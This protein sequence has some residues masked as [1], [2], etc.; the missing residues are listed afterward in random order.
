MR[1]TNTSKTPKPYLYPLKL[2]SVSKQSIIKLRHSTIE[3]S[4]QAVAD[5]LK[6]GKPVIL[7]A[8]WG[9]SGNSYAMAYLIRNMEELREM[10]PK[11]R[12]IPHEYDAPRWRV[13]KSPKGWAWATLRT[14]PEN[15]V[16]VRDIKNE[17]YKKLILK[18]TGGKQ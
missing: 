10:E 15:W 4:I 6:K 9:R 12:Y 13:N 14:K 7:Y 17:E 3:V 5:E 18:K 16:R 2:Q 1:K 11:V 8:Y